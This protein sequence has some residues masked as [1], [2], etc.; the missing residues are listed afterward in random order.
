[1]QSASRI[2]RMSALALG[3]AGALAFAQV[4]ASGF[5]LRE[6]S[7]KNLGRANA[8]SAVSNGDASVVSLNPAAMAGLDSNT[9]QV[10]LTAIDLDADFAGGGNHLAGTPLAQ[11]IQ[12]GNGGDPGDITA[13]PAL[14]AVFPMSGALEGLTFGASIGAPF[15]LRTEYEDGWVG[16]YHAL[17]SDVKVVDLTLSASLESQ[18]GFSIGAGIIYERAEAELSKAIDYGTA[19]CAGSGNPLNCVNPAFPFR[20][21]QYDGSI[22][23]SGDSTE[24]GFIIGAQI[25]PNDRLAIGLSH[26]TEID[27]KLDGTVDFETRGNPLLAAG[28]P[29]SAGGAEVTLPSITT[30]SVRYGVTDDVRILADYQ[31]TG[32]SALETLEIR[33]A[34]GALV[35]SEEFDWEDTTFVSIGAEFDLSDAFTLRAGIAQDESPTRDETRTPRLPDDDRML[36][37]VGASWNVSANLTVDAA[38]QRITIDD[39]TIDIHAETGSSLVGSFDGSADLFGISAQYRF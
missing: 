6:S 32:W 18:D 1:M 21:G 31:E 38:Y 30:L 19:L 28:F 13:V 24:F 5:Q 27:H 20:P 22:N 33:R 17:T 34:N 39:P 7:V 23:V 29:D 35:G 9:V 8:G 36:Y 37:S 4:Q 3:I 15:G 25:R 2:T 10:D 12:G 11:P 16:R 14:A 26:R